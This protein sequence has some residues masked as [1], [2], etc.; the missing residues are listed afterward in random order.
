MWITALIFLLA[1]DAADRMAIPGGR[2]VPLFGLD[3]AQKDFPVAGFEIDSH[4]VTNE[5]Y[6]A[7][8]RANPEWKKQRA[9]AALVDERYLSHFRNDAPP[10]GYATAPVVWVSWFAAEAY[11]EWRGGRL[12]STL[13]WEYVAAASATERDASTDPA[14]VARILAWYSRANRPEALLEGSLEKNVY[15]VF[16]MHE[17]VWEWTLD[18]NGAF[19]TADNRQD[20]DRMKNLFCGNGATGSARR[21]DYAA[22]MRYALRS[23]LS[24]RSSLSNLGFRCAASAKE[25][26]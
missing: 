10:A 22:F 11:C 19:N 3:T 9:S 8:L 25:P 5:A 16:G 26:K 13:E 2:F 4:F 23:S 12:P 1:S 24:A 7:F 21:E 20:G 18:F 15:G 14:F 17:R 6:V